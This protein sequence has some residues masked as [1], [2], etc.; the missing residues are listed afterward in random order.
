[1]AA[2]LPK[3]L[4]LTQADWEA[5]LEKEHQNSDGLWL[6]IAKKEGGKSSVS[7]QEALDIAL[8]F[9]WID[10]QK[11]KLDEEY[12]LQKFTPRRK[13]SPW[14]AIN[15]EKVAKL[16]EAGK[17]REAG[18]KEIERAKADGR[19]DKAYQPQ[20]KMTVPE[21]FQAALDA[22]PAANAFFQTLKS[23]NRYSMLYRIQ[24][25]KRPETREKRIREF[26]AMLAEGKTL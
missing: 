24:D 2:E 18:L 26:V 8:C 1:M 21:D 9:G 10:G 3:I 7:Y 14:S 12:W 13:Q 6:Q 19:W 15:V 16:I 22:N 4:F 23:V 17:M 20:S 25:A 5:W 11:G